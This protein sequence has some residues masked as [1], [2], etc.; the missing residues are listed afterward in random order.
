[1]DM[2]MKPFV[3]NPCP[4]CNKRS[5]IELTPQQYYDLVVNPA[6]PHIQNIFLDWTPGERELLIT[7]MHPACWAKVFSGEE[8]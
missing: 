3:T 1:M 2:E 7:G 5:T 8:E 6:R 4:E